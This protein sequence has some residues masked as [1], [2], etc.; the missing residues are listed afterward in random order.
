MK[1][2]GEEYE[3][4][5]KNTMDQEEAAITKQDR[6]FVGFIQAVRIFRTKKDDL[7][8]LYMLE[9]LKFVGCIVCD[10]IVNLENEIDAEGF[11]AESYF[12][13]EE[14][15]FSIDYDT[16]DIDIILNL[17]P[18][19]IERSRY[20]E[21]SAV[22]AEGKMQAR[23]VAFLSVSE[24]NFL[25]EIASKEGDSLL[26]QPLIH[27]I[28]SGD[29][30]VQKEL[31]VLGE[32]Y[33]I[34]D[35]FWYLYVKTNFKYIQE[36]FPDKNTASESRTKAYKAILR[37]YTLCYNGL[38]TDP[39]FERADAFYFQYAVLLLKHK[40][41]GMKQLV[42]AQTVFHTEGM[43]SQVEKLREKRP[44]FIRLAYLAGNICIKNP[45]FLGIVPR[46]MRVAI[47]LM[48]QRY[49]RIR[50][51]DFLYYQLGRYYEKAME[52]ISTAEKY[53][54]KA[55]SANPSY[56]RA[57]YK[58]VCRADRE[59][60]PETAAAY[61]VPLLQILIN[62]YDLQNLMPKQQVYSFKSM[63]L[64]GKLM[65]ALEKYDVA[66]RYFNRALEISNAVSRFYDYFPGNQEVFKNVQRQGMP[67][68]Q[69][70]VE[71]NRCHSMYQH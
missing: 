12:D 8:A 50:S 29:S 39:M 14:K 56:Y 67:Q 49:G 48:E 1:I 43:L 38:V 66:E 57:L 22:A 15:D 35:L 41:N 23:R 5:R 45:R 52:D 27:T 30:D 24:S 65:F 69:I 63:S 54:N 6:K 9:F 61:A 33:K 68:E 10:R 60:H 44:D 34:T 58:M 32:K 36:H 16:Y 70:A 11:Y 51:L 4:E 53:Y 17:G 55:N 59:G 31:T 13:D 40:L 21:L 25:D 71:L 47:K 62:D 64:Y 7:I 28:W 26:L 19:V 42:G 37:S 2:N 20:T 3:M 46:Y 18:D